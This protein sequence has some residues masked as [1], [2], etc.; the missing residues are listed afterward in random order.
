[1]GFFPR[2]TEQFGLPLVLLT[3]QVN[4]THFSNVGAFL[5]MYLLPRFELRCDCVSCQVCT[6]I[7]GKGLEL[8]VPVLQLN[9]K[10]ILLLRRDW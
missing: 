3:E 10:A 9:L 8:P 5:A 6:L 1:M 4:W 7:F 2:L